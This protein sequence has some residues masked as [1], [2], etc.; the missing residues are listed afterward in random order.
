[1]KNEYMCIGYLRTN[2]LSKL[3]HLI[4]PFPKT[5]FSISRSQQE[6]KKGDTKYRWLN[7]TIT[8]TGCFNINWDAWRDKT[9]FQTVLNELTKFQEKYHYDDFVVNKVELGIDDPKLVELIN[10]CLK[11]NGYK[12]LYSSNTRFY[13][14]FSN[15]PLAYDTINGWDAKI[16]TKINL[17]A[18]VNLKF[19]R[20]TLDLV[21]IESDKR[22][23][24]QQ[25]EDIDFVLHD[26]KKIIKHILSHIDASRW[27]QFPE[28]KECINENTGEHPKP[29]AIRTYEKRSS[30]KWAFI[31]DEEV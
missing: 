17:N 28:V 7:F 29:G 12:N 19:K 3:A 22:K 16:I 20:G 26:S 6:K 2:C 31:S 18:I 9:S 24:R 25:Q 10:D 5:K 30:N 13:V 15:N 1:M 4:D 11:E 8:G 27:Y 21:H 23:A 14:T